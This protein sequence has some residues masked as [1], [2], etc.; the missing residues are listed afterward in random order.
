ME[1][2][3]PE[4]SWGQGIQGKLGKGRGTEVKFRGREIRRPLAVDQRGAEHRRDDAAD[5]EEGFGPV[6][7]ARIRAPEPGA[8]GQ[9]PAAPIAEGQWGKGP[10]P[11]GKP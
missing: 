5:A 4:G 6:E 7:K 8:E 3:L 1:S 10:L 9:G 2:A 11:D